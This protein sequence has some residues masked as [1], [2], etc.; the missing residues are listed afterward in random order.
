MMS[1]KNLLIVIVGPTGIGKTALSIQLAKQFKTE[2]VSADSRQ[3]FRETEIGTAKPDAAELAAAPHHLV[4]TLSIHDDYSVGDF[5]KEAISL[6][7]KI[8]QKHQAAIMVG[9]SGLYVDAVCNGLDQF[10]SIDVS[11]RNDLNGLFAQQGIAPLQEE[12]KKCDPEYYHVVDKKNPQRLI[13][14]LEVIRATGKTFTS[15]RQRKAISRPFDRIKIGLEMEREQLYE[16]IDKRMDLMIEAGLF[17]EAE[18]LFPHRQ[19]NALQTVGY[20]EIFGYLE[21]AYD[22]KEAIRLLKR[23]SRRYAKRQMT[24]FKRDETTHWFAPNNES[25]IISLV[26]E[27]LESF[28]A[29]D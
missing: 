29:K 7:G 26:Q 21:G 8:H 18:W 14:A 12:L 17:Q 1:R 22:K 27:K 13:R 23:N 4:N 25:S 20:Q 5:E 19:L 16:R 3:F 10:P 15:Y 24:W 11:F 28:K 2:I 9:G 6:I